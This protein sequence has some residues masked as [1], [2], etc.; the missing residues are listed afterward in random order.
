MS[1]SEP[2]VEPTAEAAAEAIPLG[3]DGKPLSK[4][5]RKKLLQ[6]QKKAARV[7]EREAQKAAV[8]ASSNTAIKEDPLDP[9]EYFNF[10]IEKIDSR[11]VSSYPHKF[12]VTHTAQQFIDQFQGLQPG[13]KVE[14]T[15][16]SLAGRV[17][18]RHPQSKKLVFYDIRNE[19]AQLQLWCDLKSFE[20]GEEA[21]HEIHEL[22][23]RGDFVGVTGYASRTQRGELSVVARQLILLSPCLRMLPGT[24]QPITD[25]ETRYRQRYLDLITNH[26]KVRETFETRAGIIRYIRNYLD[27]RR[28]LE[29]ETPMM[30]SIAGGA[31]AKPF[32]THHNAIN[33]DLFLRIAPELYLKMLV[34]GG[35]ERVYEIGRNFRNEGIDLTHNPEFTACEFYMAYADYNEIME[36]TED[37]LLGMVQTLKGSDTIPIMPF[38]AKPGTQPHNVSFKRP[39]R[40]VSMIAELERILKV[41]FPRPL[42]S[43]ECN[44]F[45]LEVCVSNGVECTPPTTTARLLD[46]LVGEYIEP[47][48]TQPTFICDHPQLMSPLAKWNRNDPEL[49]ERFELFINGK[50]ICN[51]YTELNEPRVQRKC[52]EAQVKDK[53]AGDEEAQ[54]IDENFCTSLEYALPPTGGWGI[55]IDR[56]CMM[57]TGQVN[58][59]EVLLFPAMR[60]L[61]T[62]QAASSVQAVPE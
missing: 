58:I 17:L 42:D 21:F 22:I 13:E 10:R 11:S 4:N 26:G 19:G 6:E 8:A 28:F 35:L 20:A 1:A 46:K 55:G 30:G 45:L 3:P 16:V 47:D 34:V 61:G 15:V 60:P 48:C 18:R 51:A 37:M 52:F 43:P 27:S 31:A 25:Q 44:A 41:T 2:A 49:T 23:R 40:R 7:A 59:K 38:E 14:D 29:V 36:L 9:A 33:S 39:F 57:L 53:D 32:V 12:N 50:E 24:S 56:L 5:A 62:S 54:M